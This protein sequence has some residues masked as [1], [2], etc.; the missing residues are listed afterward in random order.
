MKNGQSMP[1]HH[2]VLARKHQQHA[3]ECYVLGLTPHLT[4]RRLSTYTCAVHKWM[5]LGTCDEKSIIR[6]PVETMLFCLDRSKC[7]QQ[8]RPMQRC[9]GMGTVMRVHKE[10]LRRQGDKRLQM[11]DQ[12]RW[13]G[14][15]RYSGERTQ[16]LGTVIFP[17]FED[18]PQSM[19]LDLVW[20]WSGTRA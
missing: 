1:G 12:T 13:A 15:E 17:T 19:E 6:M 4:H 8:K 2:E 3:C 16:A 11:V 5:S 14:P 20:H 9:T 18:L 10:R 7:V